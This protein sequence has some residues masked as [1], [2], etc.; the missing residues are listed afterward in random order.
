MVPVRKMPLA[1]WQS[2]L[3]TTIPSECHPSYNC[4]CEAHT[5]SSG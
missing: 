4:H 5:K 1:P 3:R 2:P